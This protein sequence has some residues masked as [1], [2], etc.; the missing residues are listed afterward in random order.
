VAGLAGKNKQ[1]IISDPRTAGSRY[2][3]LRENGL[4]RSRTV[5]LA[6]Q[7]IKIAGPSQIVSTPDGAW[8]IQTGADIEGLSR[9]SEDKKDQQVDR[10]DGQVVRLGIGRKTR[11]VSEAIRQKRQIQVNY[12]TAK[13]KKRYTLAPL[14]VKR[15][16]KKYKKNHFLLGYSEQEQKVRRLRM[17]RIVSIQVDKSTFDPE[18]IISRAWPGKKVQWHLPRAWDGTPKAAT[19][20]KEILDEASAQFEDLDWQLDG[21]R[22]QILDL[23]PSE[24]RPGASRTLLRRLKESGYEITP[25]HPGEKTLPFWQTMYQEGFIDD[26]PDTLTTR[27]EAMAELAKKT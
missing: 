25:N 23:T 5:P 6:G 2:I 7:I 26:D 20:A 22:V 14:D 12:R 3:A 13:G 24:H 11:L 9:K 10:M 17:D 27:E 15:G 16:Q 21:D 1:I 4:A 8:W 19:G 18:K